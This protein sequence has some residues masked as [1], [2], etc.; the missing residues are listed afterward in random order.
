MSCDMAETVLPRMDPAVL[1][2]LL[3]QGLWLDARAGE[4]LI[5]E[6]EPAPHLFYLAEGEAEVTTGGHPVARCPAGHFL[7]EITILSGEP[8]TATVTL[9]GRARF[10]CIGRDALARMLALYPAMRPTLEAAFVG[11]MADKLRLANQRLAGA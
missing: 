8:A 5:R 1:R 11:D 9:A 4:T 2:Q 6:G 7:G 10:W 3:D